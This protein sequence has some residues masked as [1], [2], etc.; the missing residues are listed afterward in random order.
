[1]TNTERLQANNAELRECI[2]IAESLPDVGGGGTPTPSQEKTVNITDNGTHTVTPDDGYFLSKVTANVAVPIPDGYI[3]P[4]GELEVTKNGTHDVAAYASVNVNV[5]ASGED[6]NV[7]LDAALTGSITSIDS[8]VKSLAGYACRGWSKLK[9]VNLP[10]ATSLGTYAFY[11]CTALDS[12]NVPKVTSIGTYCFYN[13][14]IE[15]VNFPLATAITQ[16]SFY[17]CESLEV[18]DFGVAKSVAQASFAHCSSLKALILRKSDAI[19]TLSVASNG[20]QGSGIANKTGYVYVPRAL[21]DTYKAAT[22][23]VN[24]ATQFRVLEDFTVDGTITGEL[25]WDKVNAAA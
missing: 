19:C 13:T 7:L 11:Y 5:A 22:N 12:I 9:T 17:S 23:W 4:S 6:P 2:E 8:T 24:Y 18:A 25:D 3:K 15:R 20:F 10:N 16:N 14:A 1:M 21:V